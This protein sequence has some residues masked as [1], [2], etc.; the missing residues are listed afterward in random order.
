MSSILVRRGLRSLLLASSLAIGALGA[1]AQGHYMDQPVGPRSLPGDNLPPFGMLD[2]NGRLVP[3][4]MTRPPESLHERKAESNAPGPTLE[5]AMAG[6]LAAVKECRRLGGY[7]AATVVDSVGDARAMLSADGADCSHVFVAHRK[8]LTALGFKMPGIKVL[9]AIAKD[10][11][12]V[13]KVTP[14]MF[15]MLGDYPINWHGEIIGAI[16]YSG[17]ID[18]PCALAG[19]KVI[20]DMLP[21]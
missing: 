4:S 14:N 10:P 5:V 12:L 9:E 16:G 15:V 20:E 21:K 18:E 6:A 17:G 13:S 3:N 11:S 7:G 1:S 2:D 19:L 8:A